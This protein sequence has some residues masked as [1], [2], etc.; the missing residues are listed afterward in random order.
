ML[1]E[2]NNVCAQDC[3]F[4]DIVNALSLVAGK[5][6]AFIILAQSEMTYIQTDG[7]IVEYQEGSLDSHHFCPDPLT[8]E[9]IAKALQSYAKGDDCWK[10]AIRWEKGIQVPNTD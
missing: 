3:T 9:C 7:E 5:E 1:L 4:G 6:D 2:I 8:F 10:T